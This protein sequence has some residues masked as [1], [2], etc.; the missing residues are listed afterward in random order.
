MSGVPA[1][2]AQ[3]RLRQTYP[4]SA[5]ERT[6]NTTRVLD[7]CRRECAY[8]RPVRRCQVSLRTCGWCIVGLKRC[9]TSRIRCR[10]G[11]ESPPV[12]VSGSPGSDLAS[13]SIQPPVHDGERR[14]F[15]PTFSFSRSSDRPEGPGDRRSLQVFAAPF[16]PLGRGIYPCLYCDCAR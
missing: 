16:R 2:V 8:S 4:V 12:P 10:A 7:A 6:T 13:S 9:S 5:L 3:L 11:H 1:S 14:A 15:P